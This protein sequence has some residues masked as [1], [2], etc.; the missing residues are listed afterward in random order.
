MILLKNRKNSQHAGQ[1]EK[2]ASSQTGGAR[3][4]SRKKAPSAPIRLALP[5]SE[6][7]LPQPSPRASGRY[8]RSGCVHR[9]RGPA[10]PRLR[11]G[12]GRKIS[13]SGRR[14]TPARINAP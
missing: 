6:I 7:I 10:L 11:Q 9:T 12:K 8:R 14:K 5:L 2:G 4:I 1:N 13:S 3:K